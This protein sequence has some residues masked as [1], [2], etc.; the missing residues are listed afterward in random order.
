VPRKGPVSDR[1][2]TLGLTLI[3]L[4]VVVAILG[5]LSVPV[6]VRLGGG[7]VFGGARPAQSAAALLGAE[8][9]QMRDR[10]LFGRQVLGLTPGPE[11]WVWSVRQPDGGWSATGSAARVS[12][13]TLAWLVA[14]TPLPPPRPGPQ[15]D[16]LTPPVLLMPDGRGVPFSVR[17]GAGGPVCT[18]DGWTD[19]SCADL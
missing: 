16:P 11:G 8:L 19:L 18:F 13:L 1:G 2:R 5:L 9:S 3:E 12:G 15:A 6:V 7:G 4:V 10:A 14:G 17:M